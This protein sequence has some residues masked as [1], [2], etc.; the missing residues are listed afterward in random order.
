MTDLTTAKFPCARGCG[1]PIDV[2]TQM[3]A[4]MVTLGK[5]LEFSHDVCPNARMPVDPDAPPRRF[6]LQILVWE[7]GHL[8]DVP[9]PE[10]GAFNVAVTGAELLSGIGKTVEARTLKDAMTGPF[11]NWLGTRSMVF[12]N[13][14]IAPWDLL[15]RASAFAD[16]VTGHAAPTT[17]D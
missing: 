6:R 12:Q 17:Q 1:V 2:D 10:E 8:T 3:I 4:N 13:E 14:P 5:A 7:I 16:P 15:M 9:L 11:N